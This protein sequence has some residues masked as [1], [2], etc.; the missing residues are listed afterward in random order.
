MKGKIFATL[1]ILIGGAATILAAL[2][3]F[4]V[5]ITA[6]QNKAI[7]AVLGVVLMIAGAWFH[8]DV[9]IGPSPPSP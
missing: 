3:A 4:G 9:P 1:T 8:P 7:E 5:D 6:D 2:D